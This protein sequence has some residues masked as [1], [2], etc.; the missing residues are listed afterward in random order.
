[1]AETTTVVAAPAKQARQRWRLV[2]ARSADA[3]D[4]GGRE[5]ADAWEAALQA[6]GLPVFVPAGRARARVAFAAPLSAGLVADAELADIVLTDFEP[7]WRVRAAVSACLPS[8]WRLVDV[9]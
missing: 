7:I 8:G 3:P 2:L 1:M 9:Y 4:L 6:S 5:L